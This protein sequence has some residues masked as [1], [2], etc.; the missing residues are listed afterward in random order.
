MTGT[1]TECKV[2]DG[3]LECKRTK[4]RKDGTKVILAEMGKGHDANCRPITKDLSG[5]EKELEK[6]SGFMDKNIKTTCE[7]AKEEDKPE[8][9]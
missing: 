5:D 3:V 9:Y 8:D 7:R 2:V 6:L 1:K 4:E